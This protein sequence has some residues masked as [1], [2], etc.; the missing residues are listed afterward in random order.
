ML[1]DRRSAIKQFL[2][3]SVGIT[4]LPACK[5]EN[6]PSIALKNLDISGDDEALL[7]GLSETLIP[8]TDTPGAKD[9]M[10]HLF[11]LKMVD[12]CGTKEDQ[13]KF[14]RGMRDFEKMLKEK[15]GKSFTSCS[16]AE[17][18]S[19]LSDLE[20]KQNKDDDLSFFYGA[21]KGLTVQGYTTSKFYLTQVHEYKLVPGKYHGCVPVKA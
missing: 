1:V 14:L 3:V 11:A 7:A 8:T 17:R 21:Q 9:L 19:V 15:T 4:F 20:K 6:K 12:D 5:G 13:Q 2:I 10:A 16:A 18:E